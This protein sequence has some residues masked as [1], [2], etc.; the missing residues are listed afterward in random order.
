MKHIECNEVMNLCEHAD[1]ALHLGKEVAR[2]EK[3]I[4]RFHNRL[5]VQAKKLESM[6]EE[7]TKKI[8]E[9]EEKDAEIKELKD[10]L[11]CP[12]VTALLARNRTGSYA[13]FTSFN[14][15]IL[16]KGDLEETTAQAT[17]SKRSD[18]SAIESSPKR[19]RKSE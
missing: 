19:R 10:Q 18:L 11:S 4:W 3:Q 12:Y 14:D 1:T 8:T 9:C 13:T 6:E 15:L 2:K 7:L 16:G 5:H 17:I